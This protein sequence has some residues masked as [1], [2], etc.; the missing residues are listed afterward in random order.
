MYSDSTLFLLQPT[1]SLLAKAA[2]NAH[3]VLMV[4]VEQEDKYL[5]IS[6]SVWTHVIIPVMI[7]LVIIVVTLVINFIL[8]KLELKNQLKQKQQFL[9]TWIDLV[10]P[11]ITAQGEEFSRLAPEIKNFDS[12]LFS[13]KVLPVHL[14]KLKFLDPPT[15]I[16]LFITNRKGVTAH[17]TGLLYKLE[18][19]IDYLKGKHQI[20]MDLIDQ[21]MPVMESIDIKIEERLHHLEDEFTKAFSTAGTQEELTPLKAKFTGWQQSSDVT[22]RHFRDHHLVGL[23]IECKALA[24]K[25]PENAKVLEVSSRI[26][27]RISHLFAIKQKKCDTYSEI[28]E[29]KAAELTAKYQELCDARTGLENLR[30][31]CFLEL[32]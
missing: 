23:Q 11:H 32:K 18:N 26:L 12:Q 8:S 31:K 22:L 1:D 7:P 25:D 29:G 14:D 30:F 16:S 3:S 24:E 2:K 6:E 10:G 28:F 20:G 19:S 9:F 17:K 5:W 13:F 27:I 4:K 21:F 15:L